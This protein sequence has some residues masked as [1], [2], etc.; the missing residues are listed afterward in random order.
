MRRVDNAC[1]T[2]LTYCTCVSSNNNFTSIRTWR[3][4][5]GIE[6]HS[7]DSEKAVE[8]FVVSDIRKFLKL[9][10]HKLLLP[11]NLLIHLIPC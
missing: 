9:L 4:N 2:L 6:Q 5:S 7:S 8:I 3:I 1:H 11:C 10:F